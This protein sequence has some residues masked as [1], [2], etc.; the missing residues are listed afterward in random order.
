M[1]NSSSHGRRPVG[2]MC[3]GVWHSGEGGLYV[4]NTGTNM[5]GNI[6]DVPKMD[7]RVNNSE[8]I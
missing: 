1:V 8:N 7:I 4:A 6:S 5:V 2:G 3:I